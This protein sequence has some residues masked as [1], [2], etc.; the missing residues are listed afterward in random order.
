MIACKN[1]HIN[2]VPSLLSL[3]GLSDID[4]NTALMH[5]M[6]SKCQDQL[7]IGT[8]E[9]LINSE[10]G[11]QN[12][13]GVTSLMLACENNHPECAKLL[14]GETK[15]IN[16]KKKSALMYAAQSGMPDILTLLI[17]LECGLTDENG[18]TALA[19]AFSFC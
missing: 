9:L 4:E 5:A 17:P 2:C 6:T 13:E 3:S 18:L 7:I 8:L 16:K 1:A 11:K 15:L 14:L 12:N 19:Y 10:I